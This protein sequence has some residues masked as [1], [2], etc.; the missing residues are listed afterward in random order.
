M[1]IGRS[2]FGS[3][4]PNSETRPR[5]SLR[6]PVPPQGSPLPEAPQ[7]PSSCRAPAPSSERPPR[8][9]PGRGPTA[10]LVGVVAGGPG[11]HV[12]EHPGGNLG[13]PDAAGRA[14]RPTAYVSCHW[15]VDSFLRVKV[16]GVS[17]WRET[18]SLGDSRKCKILVE[19]LTVSLPLAPG[20]AR[21]SSGSS[22]ALAATTSGPNRHGFATRL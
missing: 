5:D 16:V 19:R 11:R 6:L 13:R 10:A 9:T 15:S 18:P 2:S 20:G 12:R 1:S 14:P 3:E 17:S 21:T 4:P 7:P 8:E 22:A